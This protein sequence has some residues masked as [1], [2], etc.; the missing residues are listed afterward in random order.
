VRLARAR[1]RLGRR[2]ERYEWL[3]VGFA[4]P[5]VV[6][7]GGQDQFVIISQ[8]I[9]EEFPRSLWV[10]SICSIFVSPATAPAAATGY[11]VGMGLC[12]AE[13]GAAGTIGIPD[14]L[15]Q[16]D[17]RWQWH[18][19][20]YPQIGGTGAADQ[21]ASRWAGYFRFDIDMR[22]KERL[23]DNEEIVFPVT[24][25]SGSGASIQWS[26]TFR[27]LLGVGAK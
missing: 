7:V 19:V 22:H 26:G 20:C 3:G 23:A 18:Q 10:R 16:F 8:A 25:S 14:P 2:R 11:Y 6:A 5:R 12:H 13:I 21:N 17:H 1:S 9:L 27:L 4:A 24:N 15:A